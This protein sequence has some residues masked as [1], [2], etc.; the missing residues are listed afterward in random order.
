[1]NTIPT[2]CL[3]CGVGLIDS[4][5]ISIR[6]CMSKLCLQYNVTYHNNYV[7]FI[8]IGYKYIITQYYDPTRL[9]IWSKKTELF[10]I[11]N[12]LILLLN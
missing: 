9:R 8:T 11:K 10:S 6:R 12:C 5:I 2:H 7:S 3:F 4:G 1:M